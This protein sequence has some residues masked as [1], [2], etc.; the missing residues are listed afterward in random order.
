MWPPP[1]PIRIAFFLGGLVAIAFSY[2]V[3]SSDWV[4][5]LVLFALVFVGR[6]LLWQ[7]FGDPMSRS[8]RDWAAV[9]KAPAGLV[10]GCF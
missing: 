7:R 9:Q 8:E 1:W 5:I 3:T 4:Q 10:A 6:P 2:A